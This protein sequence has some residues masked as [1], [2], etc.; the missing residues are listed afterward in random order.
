[1]QLFNHPKKSLFKTNPVHQVQ[2]G[3]TNVTSVLPHFLKS[4][5][6]GERVNMETTL[7]RQPREL[8][9][10]ATP[11]GSA[12]VTVQAL[13]HPA[14]WMPNPERNFCHQI[15]GFGKGPGGGFHSKAQTVFFPGET[16]CP[17]VRACSAPLSHRFHISGIFKRNLHSTVMLLASIPF[18]QPHFS[19]IH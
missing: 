12:P 1:M 5:V 4:A 16:R 13:L 17:W 10:S 9:L 6:R 11:N 15:V 18:A 3:S 19:G 14:A 8:W 2:K 7:C